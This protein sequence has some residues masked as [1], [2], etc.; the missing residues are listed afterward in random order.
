MNKKWNILLCVALVVIVIVA[1]ATLVGLAIN[2]SCNCKNDLENN[3][4]NNSDCSDFEKNFKN[5]KDYE[6][7]KSNIDKIH[8]N[9]F[10]DY[11]FSY[12]KAERIGVWRNLEKNDVVLEI[13]GNIGGVTE[14]IAKTIDPKNFVT[15][16]PNSE[17]CEQLKILANKIGKN[18]NIFNGV[19]YDEVSKLECVAK[20]NITTFSEC[21]PINCTNSTNSTNNKSFEE[22]QKLYN[23]QFNVLVIDCEGCYESLF[24]YLHLKKLFKGITKIFIEWDGTFMED[25]LLENG[26]MLV[27]YIPHID[28][29]KGVRTYLKKNFSKTQSIPKHIYRSWFTKDVDSFTKKSID[30]MM[31]LNPEYTHEIFT[32]EEMDFFVNVNFSKEISSAYNKLNIIV[33]KVDFWRYLIL[34]KYGGVYLDIDS[35]IEVPLHNL[36]KEN[37]DAIISFENNPAHYLQWALIFKKNHPILQKTIELVVENINFNKYPNNIIDTTG[38]GVFTKAINFI[39]LKNNTSVINWS[40]IEKDSDISF[41]YNGFN[42]RVYGIDFNN[43]FTFKVNI[44]IY[45]DLL[46]KNSKNYWRDDLKTKLLINL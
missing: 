15:V 18:F 4:K 23:L 44:D 1:I 29:E 13:G 33:A 22:I 6:N 30:K 28:L 45:N 46:K 8:D 3:F 21:N 41:S 17:S 39:H 12:E 31:A 26:F 24:N 27:E 14:L 5:C 42:Y 11:N 20:S 19:I 25:L 2:S 34:Y 36:I 7:S 38:P 40:F 9:L 43:L 37:D 32:D 35:T 16:E 10:A